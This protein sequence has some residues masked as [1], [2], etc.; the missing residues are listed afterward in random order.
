MGAGG[1]AL[2]RQAQVVRSVLEISEFAACAV[3]E[4]GEEALWAVAS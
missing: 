1:A 3:G 2:C 4:E